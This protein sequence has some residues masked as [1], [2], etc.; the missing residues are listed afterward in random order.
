LNLRVVVRPAASV[1]LSAADVVLSAA[2]VVLSEAKDLL[3]VAALA[4]VACGPPARPSDVLV[5]ASGTDLESANPLVTVHPLSRQIERYALLVTLARYDSALAPQ[6]Y[7]AR[8]WEFSPDH[9]RLT[10]H[11]VQ[12]LKWHD[13]T[14][15][16]AADVAFTLLAAKDPATGYM[17]A[18]DLAAVD[19]VVAV[20]DSTAVVRFSRPP[21]SFPLV[22]CELPIVPRH[23][24]QSVKRGDMKRAAYNSD[25]VGNGPFRFVERRAGQLWRY[26]RNPDF[27]AELGGPPKFD[28]LVVAVVDEATTKFAGLS[29]G[30][31]DVAG[32]SPTM[33]SLARRDPSLRVVEYPILFSTGIVF[34][35]HRPPFDDVRVRR[36]IDLSIDRERIVSVALA[37]FGRPAF[38]PVPPESPLSAS[39]EAK[40]SPAAADSI[41]DGAGWR[42]GGDGMRARAGKP[43]SFELLTVGSADNAIEQLIQSDLQARGIRMNIRQM[44]GGAFLTTMRASPKTFDA[45]ITGIPGDVSLAYLAAMYEG[46]QRGGSLDYSAF[47]DAALDA[48]FAA[49]R[50]ATTDAARRDAWRAVQKQLADS[51]PMVWVYHSRG[52]QGISAR[53]DG[54]K[55]DLRGELASLAQWE[56]KGAPGSRRQ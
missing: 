12:S 41:L 45:A 27:P 19:T 44:E 16:T 30:D 48:G 54:V 53:L 46:S 55:M 18:A 5:Y 50:A 20:D 13:G 21:A 17:R 26:A 23:K 10:F 52:V 39:V 3:F 36:A 47:H 14:P 38:G 34:N 1:V 40:P 2:D 7:A 4:L 11:L 42:R 31:L 33:A 51:L 28:G 35:V 56:P 43:L 15:T 32:I 29:S 6:P 8:R 24:L 49:T 22:L 9:R 25:P 37:G